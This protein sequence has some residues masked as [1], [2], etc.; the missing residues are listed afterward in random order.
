[1]WPDAP[2]SD[3]WLDGTAA[4]AGRAY[5]ASELLGCTVTVADHGAGVVYRGRL[6]RYDY[7]ARTAL[8][9]VSA[10]R[11]LGDPEWFY[12]PKPRPTVVRCALAAMRPHTEGETL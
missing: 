2:V 5:L 1:M 8:L 3:Y 9:Y 10:E 4:P 11:L 7:D 12:P 6:A